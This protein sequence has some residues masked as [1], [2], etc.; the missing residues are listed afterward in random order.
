MITDSIE[1]I[2]K[3]APSFPALSEVQKAIETA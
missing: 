1:N 3:Y 2:G